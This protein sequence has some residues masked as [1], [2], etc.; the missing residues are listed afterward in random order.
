MGRCGRLL[1]GCCILLAQVGHN[2]LMALK[3]LLVHLNPVL[4][5]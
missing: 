4:C 1:Q 3:T 5:H 2:D